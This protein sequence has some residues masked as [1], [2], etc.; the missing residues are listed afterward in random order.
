MKSDGDTSGETL[1]TYLLR[2]KDEEQ[3]D[4]FVTMVQKYKAG[5]K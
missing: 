1:A 2:V 5:E 4:E 3:A